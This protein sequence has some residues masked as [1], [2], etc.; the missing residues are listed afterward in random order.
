MVRL[1]LEIHHDSILPAIRRVVVESG[2]TLIIGRTQSSDVCME[3]DSLMS[4]RHF[5]V[6]CE[7]GEFILTDLQS[8]NGTL[9]N[10]QRVT[11]AQIKHGDEIIA[12][13]TRFLASLSC[14]KPTLLTEI[15]RSR[16]TWYRPH[17]HR[18]IP[19]SAGHLI[20]LLRPLGQSS[21]LTNTPYP[22]AR[23]RVRS[24]NRWQAR[25]RT[26]QPAR[27]RSP[28]GSDRARCTCGKIRRSAAAQPSVGN[29]QRYHP[30]ATENCL[31]DPTRT[32]VLAHARA[33]GKLWPG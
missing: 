12:G 18:M 25:R 30:A 9:H 33:I 23:S 6:K 27:R 24:Q 1:E 2:Q 4:S 8:T 7:G 11:A 13:K 28:R 10:G 14:R 15:P 5:Q 26:R 22:P 20:L 29:C 19:P 16:T 32:A 21:N 31:R 3:H 17:R